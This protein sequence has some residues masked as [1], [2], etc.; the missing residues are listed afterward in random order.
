MKKTKKIH[1]QTPPLWE[2]LG[3]EPE[4]PEPCDFKI[5]EFVIFTNEFG[6]SFR[7]EVIG[8]AKDSSFQGRFIYL[9]RPDLPIEGS[10]W[11]FPHRP[12]ELKH[13]KA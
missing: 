6:V 9:R 3:I 2:R 8:Y 1:G 4:P 11:W 12:N 7:M 5:G 13:E 10:G